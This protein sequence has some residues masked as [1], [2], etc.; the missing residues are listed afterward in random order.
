MELMQ[1]LVQSKYKK[2]LMGME[3]RFAENAIEAQV[4]RGQANELYE[5]LLKVLTVIIKTTGVFLPTFDRAL[6]SDAA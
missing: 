4:I 1:S 2:P 5:Q 6:F 3:Q